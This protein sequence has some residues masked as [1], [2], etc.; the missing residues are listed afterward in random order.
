MTIWRP[1]YWDKGWTETLIL[2]VR[3]QYCEFISSNSV[4]MTLLHAFLR[5][6][7]KD[8]SFRFKRSRPWNWKPWKVSYPDALYR[9]VLAVQTTNAIEELIP[10]WK[11]DYSLSEFFP[12]FYGRISW[13]RKLAE[14]GVSRP[15]I[16]ALA[17]SSDHPV[18]FTD[19]YYELLRASPMQHEAESD[20]QHLAR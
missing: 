20:G 10:P 5:E 14:H 15:L 8:F 17:H 2:T 19:Y 6:V 18:T 12:I 7:S 13:L 4:E 1:S 9:R 11:E 16:A 3:C